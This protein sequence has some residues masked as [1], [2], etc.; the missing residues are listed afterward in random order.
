MKNQVIASD[1]HITGRL[2]TVLSLLII[3]AVPIAI[4]TYFGVMPNGS[5]VLSGILKVGIIYI[6]IGIIE[7]LTYGPILGPGASYLAFI[8][9]N[10]TNLKIPCAMNAIEISGVE[11]GSSESDILS[12]LSVASSTLITNAILLVGVLLLVPLTPI[13]SS[14]SLAPAFANVIPALFGALGYMFISQNWKIS[15]LPL[16]FVL[17]LF[18]ALPPAT[19]SAI[20]GGLIPIS[21]LVTI[22]GARFLYKKNWV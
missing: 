11:A 4:S 10:L 2:W 15:I 12:T 17:I 8:T 9:G 22:V 1:I 7:A 21:V 19:A 16:A 20:S 18:F 13:L 5:F 14:P 3:C 6:P